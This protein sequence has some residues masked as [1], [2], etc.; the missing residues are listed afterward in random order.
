MWPFFVFIFGSGGDLSRALSL[1]ESTMYFRKVGM[2]DSVGGNGIAL[3]RAGGDRR[4][5]FP[6][7]FVGLSHGSVCGEIE[8]VANISDVGGVNVPGWN[9]G[10]AGLK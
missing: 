10:A 3:G 4:W 6:G 2:L 1:N 9:V 5:L 8:C 7:G